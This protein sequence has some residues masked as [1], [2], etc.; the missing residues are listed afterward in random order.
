MSVSG[1]GAMVGS[2]VLASLPNR[3]RGLMLMISC[4][5]LAAALIVF[6]FSKSFVLSLIMIR[7]IG[8]GQTGRMTLSSTLLQYYVKNEYL[9]RVMALSMMQ[10]GFT[11]LSAFIAGQITEAVER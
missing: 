3:K 6:S 10:F 8:L 9:G 2:M 1:A 11:S 7:P 4:V 5:V